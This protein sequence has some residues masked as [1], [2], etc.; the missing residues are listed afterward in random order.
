MS[1]DRRDLI[2]Q[3][4][5]WQNDRMRAIKRAKKWKYKNFLTRYKRTNGMYRDCKESEFSQ[6]IIKLKVRKT[7]ILI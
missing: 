4:C 3:N 6:I 7:V 2:Y 5:I 1:K